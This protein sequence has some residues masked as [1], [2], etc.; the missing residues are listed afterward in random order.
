MNGR[1][2]LAE[3]VGYGNHSIHCS[4][5]Y[6]D[7]ISSG[8]LVSGKSLIFE[9]LPCTCHYDYYWISKYEIQFL[10][11]SVCNPLGR[12]HL[13]RKIAGSTR[14]SHLTGD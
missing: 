14:E 4:Y 5:G 10:L 3:Y 7:I 8:K 6:K 9:Y 12:K 1:M 13:S 11:S 2:S